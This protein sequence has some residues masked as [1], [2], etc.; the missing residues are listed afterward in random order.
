MFV[1]L[2][3]IKVSS[4]ANLKSPYGERGNCIC[5]RDSSAGVAG[6]VMILGLTFF[7]DA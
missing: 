7:P 3:D 5:T 2:F 6:S 1:A 4:K